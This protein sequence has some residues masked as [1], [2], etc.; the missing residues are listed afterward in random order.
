MPLIRSCSPRI[1]AKGLKEGSLR[2]SQHSDI[3]L[4][5]MIGCF[6]VYAHQG[7]EPE[8]FLGQIE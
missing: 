4:M 1:P 2:F 3:Y 6:V 7:A 5:I 8:M